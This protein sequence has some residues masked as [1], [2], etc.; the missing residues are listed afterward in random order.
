MHLLFLSSLL[1]DG[2]AT[3]G[4]EIANAAIAEAYRR[5]GVR[6]TI[7]GFRREGA[8]PAE[9]D[10]IDLGSIVIENAAAS[11]PRKALWLA[12]ALASG[13]PVAA[14]KLAGHSKSALLKRLA[15]AGPVDGYIL[16]S[17]QMPIAYPFLV[18][19]KPAIFI[20]HNVEHRS[21]EENARNAGNLLNRLLYAREARI[22]KRHEARICREAAVV[23]TLSED[24]KAG[25]GLASDP[26]GIALALSI[27]RG[28]APNDDGARHNDVGL[29]GTWSWAP[30]RVGL[31]W[32]L[33]RVVPLLP[34]DISIAIAGRLDGPPPAVPHNVRFLGRV[35]DA[36]AFVKG[37]RVVALATLGGTGVQLKTIE[38][39]EEGLPAVA[40]P[41]A[42]RGINS[43]PD[44]I[45][46]ADRPEA[47]AASIVELVASERAGQSLRLDGASF[48]A[49][50][51]A[52]L[53][54]GIARGLSAFE[55]ASRKTSLTMSASSMP[56]A[57]LRQD[58]ERI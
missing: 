58:P 17:V 20:A 29:I 47:F 53:D 49:S 46:I 18:H 4:F 31:D 13:R 32:F 3:T 22:L 33:T 8:R 51:Q 43:L 14:Q 11:A 2:M 30:N 27:G 24:D 45:R 40:T 12:G 56:V 34:P 57:P 36:Q 7:A 39:F 28:D 44:N 23:H 15:E 25:L 1:P 41:A 55:G 26:R 35:P 6:L 21:A 16:N 48:A 9:D 42:L 37:S 50:Q 38:T 5:Q 19:E 54:T 52:A 10:E